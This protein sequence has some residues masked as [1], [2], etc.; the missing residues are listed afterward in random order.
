MQKSLGWFLFLV[1]S[2]L[3]NST[4]NCEELSY[5]KGTTVFFPESGTTTRINIFLQQRYS[6]YDRDENQALDNR[7]SFSTESAR[8]VISGSTLHDEFNYKLESEF[9]NSQEDKDNPPFLKDAYIGWSP[10]QCNSFTLG[11]TKTIYTREYSIDDSKLAFVDRNAASQFFSLGRQAGAVASYTS[12]ENDFEVTGGIYNGNSSSEGLNRSGSDADHTFAA[13]LR[14]NPL[15]HVDT[16]SQG[17]YV[18]SEDLS[19]SFGASYAYTKNRIGST[20]DEY[21]SDEHR[22]SQFGLL[23]FQ[24]ISLE[25]EFYQM[26]SS[27]ENASKTSKPIGFSVNLS[28]FVIPRELEIASR[29]SQVDCDTLSSNKS[30]LESGIYEQVGLGVN[31]YLWRDQ[32]KLQLGY[33]YFSGSDRLERDIELSD[34]SRW[35]LQ[36]HSYI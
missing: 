35:S 1:I 7:S 6:F 26:S 34:S 3:L 18:W 36:I 9:G 27:S 2:Y 8:F 23:H 19:L 16:L 33:D 11:Q 24:G 32:I 14:I 12:T 10:C 29:Y 21:E 13:K 20:T 28:Y 31:Y 5:A 4:A 25:G 22:V 17:D 30:C 15:G